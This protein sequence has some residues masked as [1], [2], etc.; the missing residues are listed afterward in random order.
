MDGGRFALY[1]AKGTSVIA[2]GGNAEVI[3]HRNAAREGWHQ[4]IMPAENEPGWLATDS[5][6]QR[7]WKAVVRRFVADIRAEPTSFYPTF[8]DGC[9]AS[10]IID[11]VRG[12]AGWSPVP[13]RSNP[14]SA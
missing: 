13:E 10:E 4:L 11:I 1:G 8:V 3:L 12:R 7:N 9:E 5:N 6:E 2:G 14:P